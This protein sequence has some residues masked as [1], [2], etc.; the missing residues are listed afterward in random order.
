ML[1]FLTQ[2]KGGLAGRAFALL[3]CDTRSEEGAAAATVWPGGR[4]TAAKAGAPF[5]VLQ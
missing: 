1:L 5:P 4:L 3:K 2:G